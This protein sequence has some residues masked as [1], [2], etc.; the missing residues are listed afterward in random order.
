MKALFRIL[1]LSIASAS[2]AGAAESPS[3]TTLQ[4]V[5]A[6]TNTQASQ[7]QQVSFDA[8]VTYY[9]PYARNMFV[10][11]GDSAIYVHPSVMHKVVPGDRIRVHGTMHESFRPYVESA[12]VTLISHG[13]LPKPLRPSFEQMIRAETDCKLVTV[14]A[15]IQSADLVPDLQTP[16][17]TTEASILVDGGQA[18]ASIDSDDPVRLKDLLDAEV[19]ITGVQSGLFD[20]KMQETGILFHIQSLDQV[21]ILKRAEV[22][23]WAIPITPMDRALTGYR[24]RDLSQ[25]QRV[26]GTITYSQPGVAAVLQDGSKSVWISTVSW[27]P[28]HVGAVADAIGFPEVE[29]GFLTLTRAEIHETMSQAPVIPSLFAW[30]QLALGGN[31]GHGHVFDLVSMEGTVATEVRQATQ[32]EYVL[33]SDGHLLSAIIRHPAS[34]SQ[35]PLSPMLKIPPGTQIR[36]TGI[37]ILTDAN[38]FN[39]VVP[40]NIL[41]RNVND[42]VIVSRPSLLNVRNLI[43][44]VGLLVAV[45]FAVIARGWFIEH[46][47]RRQ[48]ATLAY[49]EKRRRRILED[50]N[51]SRPLAEIIE[52]ITELVSFRLQGSPCWCQIADGARLGNYPPDLTTLRVLQ[53]DI[54]SRSGTPLGTIFAASDAL[55]KLSAEH[56]E[57]LSMGANLAALAV[58]TRRLYSDLVH[59]SEFD[60]LTDI[61]NRF[62]LEKH[63]DSLIDEA[64][65]T[66]GMFGLIYID[67]DKFKLVND[68]YGHHVGDMYLQEVAVRMKRQLRPG[69]ILARLGGDEFA[70][71]VPAV[72]HRSDVQEIALRLERCFDEPFAADGFLLHGS[73]S[74]GIAIY[75]EDATTRDAMLRAADAAMYVAK[76]TKK[77]PAMI[78]ENETAAT[79]TSGGRQ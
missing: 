54:P 74:V 69:D 47:V 9:R 67:L 48:T 43:L 79:L 1:A 51:G 11:D 30:Q 12:E 77:D 18:S 75:P 55:A 15:V 39:G 3:L 59:R 4:A 2:L 41:M 17:S 21:K 50:I 46:R 20:N 49:L 36:V 72:Q 13:Q 52:Q 8:T 22:D 66:A 60:L 37:C 64:R 42:I 71:L 7:H 25:R 45:V 10:Q 5:T 32:D 68:R 28:L 27:N 31:M 40:F 78:Q 57:G 33:E 70:V 76:K 29:N 44:L 62:A 61:Q 65:R 26:H 19:E 6:F 35:I 53:I 58:G 63:L 24:L 16:V 38:P 34:S 23:P 56:S 73:A 14:R